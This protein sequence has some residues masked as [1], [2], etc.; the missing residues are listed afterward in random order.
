[1]QMTL[2]VTFVVFLGL[3]PQLKLEAEAWMEFTDSAA[4]ESLNPNLSG[5]GKLTGFET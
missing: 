4:V 3:C 1:M 2:A 5:A